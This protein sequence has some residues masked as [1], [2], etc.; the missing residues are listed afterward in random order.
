MNSLIKV[1]KPDVAQKLS[2]SGFSYM[3]EKAQ[4]KDVF[5]FVASPEIIAHLSSHYSREDFFMCDKLFF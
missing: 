3:K 2:K 4:G 1:V 5:V